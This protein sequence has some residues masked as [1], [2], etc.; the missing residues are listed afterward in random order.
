MC[1]SKLFIDEESVKKGEEDKFALAFARIETHYFVNGGFF[2]TESQLLDDCHKISHIPTVIVQGR[3]DVVCPAK[4]AWELH[5]QLKASELIIVP[6]AGHSCSEPGI[7]S[8]LVSAT[9]KFKSNPWCI[10]SYNVVR[11]K[12][13]NKFKTF[14]AFFW[15][16]R[17]DF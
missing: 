11:C 4:T 12:I 9:D 14:K 10:S 1:T 2:R 13:H 5:K 3:Y 16:K 8:G 15:G 7:I 6:D 17:Q